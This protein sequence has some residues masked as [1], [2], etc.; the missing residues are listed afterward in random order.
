MRFGNT[1]LPSAACM[2]DGAQRR[3]TGT[4]FVSA[5]QDNICVRLGYPGSDSANARLRHQLNANLGPRIDLFE[6]A[7]Q[8]GQILNGVD[9]MVRR[10]RNQSDARRALSQ[11]RNYL[12]DFVSR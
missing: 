10:R 5:D 7:N 8:L 4:A 3:S 11:P 1:E 2:F 6:V 12:A 9:V